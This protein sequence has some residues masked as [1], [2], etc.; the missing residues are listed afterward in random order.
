ML[1][2]TRKLGEGITIGNGIRVVILGVRGNQVR[3]GI[4]APPQTGVYRDEIYAK[5]VDENRRAAEAISGRASL[6]TG[7]T[8]DIR[9]RRS[10]L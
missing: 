5:I 4:D 3:V 1:V 8:P 2:L 7:L 6:P 9:Q 10:K